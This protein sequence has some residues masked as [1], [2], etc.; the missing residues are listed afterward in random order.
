MEEREARI[1]GEMKVK[2]KGERR[3]NMRKMKVG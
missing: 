2:M 3:G 1:E